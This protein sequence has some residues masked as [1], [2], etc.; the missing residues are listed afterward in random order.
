MRV[1]SWA[2]RC[3]GNGSERAEALASPC[4]L[5]LLGQPPRDDKAGETLGPEMAVEA[6]LLSPY[7]NV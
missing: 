3:G 4:R 5:Q 7:F 1:P 6:I 2:G